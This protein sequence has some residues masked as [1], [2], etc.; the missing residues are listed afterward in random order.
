MG[1]LSVVVAQTK[2][3]SA[4]EGRVIDLGNTDDRVADDRVVA[5]KKV[6]RRLGPRG[7]EVLRLLGADVESYLPSRVDKRYRV[8]RTCLRRRN[9]KNDTPYPN[10]AAHDR[11]SGLR[12]LGVEGSGVTSKVRGRHQVEILRKSLAAPPIPELMTVVGRRDCTKVR[13][14][15]PR[16]PLEAGKIDMTILDKPTN[17]MQRYRPTAA[18]TQCE[19][20]PMRGGTYG[21]VAAKRVAR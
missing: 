5:E 10:E 1:R 18:D 4:T 8:I 7:P 2:G 19:R 15:V 16:P 21:E 13:N 14:Q 11:R 6:R 12:H 17:R 9:R 20:L 3:T